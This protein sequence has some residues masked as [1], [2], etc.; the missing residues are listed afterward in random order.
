MRV[1]DIGQQGVEE[2][3]SAPFHAG[4]GIQKINRNNN[5]GLIAEKLTHNTAQENH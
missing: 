4:K 3:P 5:R 2:K 1:F